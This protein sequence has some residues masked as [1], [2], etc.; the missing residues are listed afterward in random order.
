[1]KGGR[2]PLA[3]S[4]ESVEG[5]H[6]AVGGLIDELNVHSSLLTFHYLVAHDL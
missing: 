5:P 2:N 1:M 4:M 3:L 6:G